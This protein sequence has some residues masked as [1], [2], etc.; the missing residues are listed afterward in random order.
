MSAR[1]SYAPDAAGLR[2]DVEA[3]CAIT[4]DSAGAGE[5]AAAVWAR[6]R[7]GELGV[8]DTE[9]QPYRGRRTNSWSFAAHSLAGLAAQRIG[10][11]R[12]AALALGAL[13]SL[14][15]DASGAWP[16]RRRPFGQPGGAN[17][18]ACIPARG[19]VR[20]TAVL[21]AHLDAAKTGLAWHPRVTQN[22]A[23]RHLRTRSVE[24]VM[25]LQ[26]LGLI[27]ATKHALLAHRLPTPLRRWLGAVA[28]VLNAAAIALN[29][30][31]ARSAVVPGANDNAS[32][33]AAVLDVARALAAEPLDHVEVLVGLVGCE[34]S[35]MGGMSALLAARPPLAARSA[36]VLSL[37]TV[38]SGTPIVAAAEGAVRMHRY[39][40]RDLAL[41][42]EGAALAGLAAPR[43]LADRRLDRSARRAARRSAGDL[44]AVDGPRLLPALPPSERPARARR[45][46][47]RRV[48]RA[49]RPRH[50][51]RARPPQR[52]AIGT[53][54]LGA[55]PRP[56]LPEWRAMSSKSAKNKPGQP[57]RRQAGV[58]RLAPQRGHRRDRR[59]DRRGRGRRRDRGLR[60]RRRVQRLRVNGGTAASS[61]ASRRPRTLFDGVPQNGDTIGESDAPVTMYEFIDYQCPFCKQFRL[62]DLPGGRRQGVKE[63]QAEDRH[64][65]RSTFIGPDSEKAARAAAAAGEQNKEA[66]FTQLFYWNQGEENAGYVTDEFIDKIY[67]EIGVDKA[68]A[69]AY[70]KSAE[71]R[72]ADDRGRERGRGV[73]R[74]SARRSFVIGETGGPYEK[75]EVDIGDAAAIKAAVDSLAGEAPRARTSARDTWVCGTLL[76]RT[77]GYEV[78]PYV[79]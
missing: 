21:V 49:D 46:G 60:R 24:P 48:M 51:A 3:L 26:A 44:A 38:G 35:G 78:L 56:P 74:S 28:G 4:R 33:V 12:G 34:E 50:A 79:G 42:D 70:R 9:L 58:R 61:P 27:A 71:S 1:G 67:D 30:D 31:I 68:K 55:L 40:E 43:A 77:S 64:R 73:R 5:R 59:R 20:A 16:W 6:E 15:R 75:L 65:A 36:L 37:D 2:A 45:L 13:V 17:A 14:E 18:V 52:A 41:A 47:L 8:S 22:G 32:G 10:G 29:L 25:G 76:R 62:G 72:E 53:A 23:A 7:L 57:A 63:R 19:D 39:R 11:A 66:D 69:N 54:A